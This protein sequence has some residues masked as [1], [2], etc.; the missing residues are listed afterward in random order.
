MWLALL[1]FGIGAGV[2]I[3]SVFFLTLPITLFTFVYFSVV[4]YDEH[5]NHR[6]ID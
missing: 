4:R 6:T 3:K 2:W 1:G 5:G